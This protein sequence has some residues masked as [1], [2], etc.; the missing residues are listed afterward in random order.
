[1]SSRQT[2]RLPQPSLATTW[3]GT[4]TP[5]A[6]PRRG[7]EFS[8]RNAAEDTEPFGQDTNPEIAIRAELKLK[9]VR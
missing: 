6:R 4:P 8:S 1:M 2:P 9:G 7:H 3:P 5:V